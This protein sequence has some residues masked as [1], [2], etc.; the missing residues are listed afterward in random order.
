MVFNRLK[1]IKGIECTGAAKVMQLKCPELFVM[2]DR[3]TRGQV[4][5]KLYKDLPC[6]ASR[7]WF[8]RKYD[9]NGK[10]YVR[11]LFDIQR[12]F[13]GLPDNPTVPRTLAKTI[14]EFYYVKIT[15][16]I[17]DKEAREAIMKIAPRSQSNA[18]T[19]KELRKSAEATQKV[20]QHAVECLVNDGEAGNRSRGYA[21][22]T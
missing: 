6:V 14:D 1:Q 18:M 13:S 11:F 17:Q 8:Y 3:Y 22:G 19:L 2:W 7:K 9:E 12:R 16:A 10:G 20:A 5:E 21:G 4:D 15:L